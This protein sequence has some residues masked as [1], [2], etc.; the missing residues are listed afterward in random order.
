M[1]VVRVATITA[2]EKKAVAGVTI[3]GELTLGH[4][5]TNSNSKTDNN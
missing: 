1:F 4:L 5:L 3:G 2:G